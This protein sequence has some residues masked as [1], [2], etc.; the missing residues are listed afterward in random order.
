LTCWDGA[1]PAQGWR[2]GAF[3]A[4]FKGVFLPIKHGAHD[5]MDDLRCLERMRNLRC[6][7][8]LAVWGRLPFRFS[9]FDDEMQFGA[10]RNDRANG[11]EPS[12]T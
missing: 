11:L 1:G 3:R 9:F 2:R 4:L 7:E 12:A 8:W 6:F 10:D 5:G